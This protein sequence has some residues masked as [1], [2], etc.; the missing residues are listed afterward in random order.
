MAGLEE[1]FIALSDGFELAREGLQLVVVLKVGALGTSNVC[2]KLGR[3]A[4]LSIFLTDKLPL[5]LKQE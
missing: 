3:S 5:S 2:V 4:T 1:R